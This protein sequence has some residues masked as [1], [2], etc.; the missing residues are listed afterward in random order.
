MRIKSDIIVKKGKNPGNK[1]A[2]FCGTHGNEQ[3]GILAVKEVL[4][5]IHIQYGTVYFVFVNPPAIQKNVR[6]LEKNLNRCF[7]KKNKPTLYEDKRV[8]ELMAILDTCDAL[9]DIHASTSK[10]PTPFI[11]CE[12]KSFEV[13][14]RMN[15]GIIS[16]GWDEIEPGAADGYMHQKNKIGVCIE[17]GSIHDNKKHVHLAI[18]SIYQFLYH[19]KCTTQRVDFSMHKKKIVKVNKAIIKPSNKFVF[20]KAY[21][22]FEVLKNGTVFATDGNTSY[23]AGQN[24]CIIFPNSNALIGTEAC[25]LGKFAKNKKSL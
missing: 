21:S 3:V 4:K 17:C 16:Y 24:E 22:D 18:Q 12:K 11:I 7:Y 2:I 9:L 19:F 13:A 10:D 23:T 25:I 20:T 1:I 5:T 15:F 8:A 14:E 6:Q